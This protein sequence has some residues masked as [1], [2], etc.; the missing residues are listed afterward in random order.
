MNYSFQYSMKGV[1]VVRP[2]G[3]IHSNRLQELY[4]QTY[5]TTPAPQILMPKPGQLL[6]QAKVHGKSNSVSF[7]FTLSWNSVNLGL[8]V[9]AASSHWPLFAIVL[10]GLQ[11]GDQLFQIQTKPFFLFSL[12]KQRRFKVSSTATELTIIPLDSN[13]QVWITIY[14]Q[15]GCSEIKHVTVSEDRTDDVFSHSESTEEDDG[16]PMANEFLTYDT[17]S[18]G[19]EWIHRT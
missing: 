15:N 18:D 7:S 6:L 12:L 14:F 3:T 1:Y 9:K 19:Y 8:N 11:G 17:G 5:S 4:Q 2:E 13:K 10:T 16:S